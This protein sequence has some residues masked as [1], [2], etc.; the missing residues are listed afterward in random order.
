MSNGRH[1]CVC[2]RE[3]GKG[4]VV[5]S[6]TTCK[7]KDSK[8]GGESVHVSFPPKATDTKSTTLRTTAD[9]RRNSSVRLG[10]IKMS[11]TEGEGER[12]EEDKETAPTATDTKS[13]SKTTI[14]GRR[15]SS[16][17]SGAIE[18]SST[19]GQGER[20][21]EDKETE[22]KATDAKSTS[23]TTVDDRRKSSV[24]S[25]AIEMSSTEGEGEHPEEDEETEPKATDTKSA[26][27]T[28]VDDRRKSSVPSGA[29]EMSSTEDEG[30]RPEEDEETDSFLKDGGELDK[31]YGDP[32]ATST[33]ENGRSKE[34]VKTIEST[35]Q[36]EASIYVPANEE[37][38]DETQKYET[39]PESITD[40][41]E[42][43]NEQPQNTI[44]DEPTEEADENPNDVN[45]MMVT[46]TAVN[47]MPFLDN[48]F[49]FR[50]GYGSK[51][52]PSFDIE[53]KDENSDCTVEIFIFEKHVKDCRRTKMLEIINDNSFHDGDSWIENIGRISFPTGGDEFRSNQSSRITLTSEDSQNNRSDSA[54]NLT[55]YEKVLK[56][57]EVYLRNRQYNEALNNRGPFDIQFKKNTTMDNKESTKS[58]VEELH[59][60]TV[61][62]DK[63]AQFGGVHTVV[64]ER[65]AIRPKKWYDGFLVCFGIRSPKDVHDIED[66]DNQLRRESSFLM[67]RYLRI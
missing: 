11:S 30:E 45:I 22:P 53:R 13:T 4:P 62:T 16:V 55:H 15:K 41:E 50:Q 29:I 1:I 21:E 14:D 32:V 5:I 65:E 66:L 57:L 56:M 36:D 46:E 24:P 43:Q 63:S 34:D 48:M 51:S 3:H 59:D 12:P 18:M 44:V 42:P 6:I 28:T 25:G 58:I 27:K 39:P 8:N 38:L 67:T 31:E 52:M 37:L 64:R 61:K 60:N 49:K 26:S 17:P 23:K 10:A 19:E 20:P 35:P 9:D 7:H 47:T 54:K 33:P 2:G 40:V